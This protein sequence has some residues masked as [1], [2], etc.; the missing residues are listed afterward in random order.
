MHCERADF[1]LR[2][3]VAIIHKLS[4]KAVIPG[5]LAFRMAFAITRLLLILP[6]K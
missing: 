1:M 3:P 2:T 4:P 6:T 5:Y